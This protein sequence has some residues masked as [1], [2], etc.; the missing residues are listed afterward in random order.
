MPAADQF[1][2]RGATAV[3][4]TELETLGALG[5]AAPDVIVVRPRKAARD[6]KETWREVLEGAPELEWAAPVLV[7]EHGDTHYPTGD[8]TVRFGQAPS[9][10]ELAAFAEAHS[11]RLMRRNEFVAAQVSFSPVDPR[12]TYLPDLVGVLT[13]AHGVRIAWANTVSRYHRL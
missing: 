8:V 9:D 6:P 10:P 11:L 3:H 12:A 5:A 13:R 7:D 2:V 1:V 4:R